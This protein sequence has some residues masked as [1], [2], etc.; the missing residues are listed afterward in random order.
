ML[1]TA[2]C[3][4]NYIVD[5][6]SFFDAFDLKERLVFIVIPT[7]FI[8][9]YVL[10]ASTKRFGKIALI[11]GIICYVSMILKNII[12]VFISDSIILEGTFKIISVLSVAI[13][14]ISCLRNSNTGKVLCLD[15][16]QETRALINTDDGSLS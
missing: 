13:L 12:Y 5:Y 11:S 3:F 1:V 9:L 15:R 10:L 6:I 2:F 14:I 7:L 8:E 4:R 16:A